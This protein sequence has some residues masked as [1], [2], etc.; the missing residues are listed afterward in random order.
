[1]DLTWR[2]IHGKRAAPAEIQI[3]TTTGTATREAPPHQQLRQGGEQRVQVPTEQGEQAAPPPAAAVAVPAALDA[4]YVDE[5]SLPACVVV[6]RQAL[7]SS[8]VLWP[9][10]QAVAALPA[11]PLRLAGARVQW[12]DD[13][14]P[15]YVLAALAA[16]RAL[17]RA[18]DLQLGL[19]LPGQ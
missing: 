15:I 11:A 10:V 12:D 7:L 13:N 14:A 16:R 19:M 9:A 2:E 17:E 5:R 4:L 8:P 6:A 1:M 18:C 3:P